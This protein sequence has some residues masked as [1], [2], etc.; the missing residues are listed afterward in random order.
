MMSAGISDTTFEKGIR[1]HEEGRVLGGAGHLG[2]VY[3]MVAGDSDV[4][5]VHLYIEDDKPVTT[6]HRCNC[7]A[8]VPCSHLVAAL[9][10]WVRGEVPA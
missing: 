1:L 4:W 8:H 2:H 7:P 10:A 9:A 5:L 3:V 6:L